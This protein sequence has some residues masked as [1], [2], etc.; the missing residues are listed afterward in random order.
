MN[1]PIR[2][3]A[4]S[5]VVAALYAG[6]TLL[7]APISFGVLQFRVSEVLCILPFFFP[8]SVWGL[9][10]GCAI[11]N[12]MSTFGPLDIIFGSLASL[13]AALCT[14]QIGK[15]SK[16]T[17]GCVLACLPPV[18]FNG[19]II[20]AMATMMTVTPDGFWAGFVLNGGQIAL[21]ELAVMYVAGLPIMLWGRKKGVFDRLKEKFEV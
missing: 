20:G 13:L 9:F 19:I 8:S 5:A 2:K 21:E 15:K 7:L 3:I 1:T 17:M 11:A 4:F 16:G 12:M 18:I 14:M 10:I 6:L